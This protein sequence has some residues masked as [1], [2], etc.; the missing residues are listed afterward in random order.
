LWEIA[1]NSAE[2]EPADHRRAREK[3][4]KEQKARIG[5]RSGRGA[6][7]VGRP[8]NTVDGQA[9]DEGTPRRGIGE[10]SRRLVDPP[11]VVSVVRIRREEAD[12]R[13]R[14]EEQA[15]GEHAAASQLDAHEPAKV[16]LVERDEAGER[17][18]ARGEEDGLDEVPR[19]G[20]VDRPREAGEC[21]DEPSE[22]QA[23][24]GA[25]D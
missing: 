16:G 15:R 10:E 14:L 20:R 17:V 24:S 9:L 8:Q 23:V 18:E 1:R 5:R 12:V 3:V 25:S 11:F 6:D 13:D 22:E 21:E 4:R 2:P 7:P 19:R